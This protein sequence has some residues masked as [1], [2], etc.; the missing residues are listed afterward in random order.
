MHRNTFSEN[1]DTRSIF[2]RRCRR[3]ACQFAY[4]P[5]VI[6][7]KTENVIMVQKIHTHI[8]PVMTS[9]V[10]AKSG[11]LSRIGLM[12]FSQFGRAHFGAASLLVQKIAHFLFLEELLRNN[13]DIVPTVFENGPKSRIQHC[14]RSEL[15]LHF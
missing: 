15:H 13:E 2:L 8:D 7:F 6:I 1:F 14:E 3:R 10:I 5:V 9:D 4:D 12:F 11:N